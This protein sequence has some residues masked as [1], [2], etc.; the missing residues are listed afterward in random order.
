[1]K[2][3]KSGIVLGILSCVI[4]CS[5]PVYVQK[6]VSANLAKYRSY[7]WV[8]TQRDQNDKRSNA[9]AFAEAA[10]HNAA[11]AELDKRG[12]RE[13]N[14]NPDVLLSYDILVQRGTQA[15]SDPMYTRPF[16]R[17]YYNPWARRWGTIYYPSQFMGYDTY[18][19]PVREGTLTVTMMDANND[20]P[21]WQAWTT[22]Q[23]NS[24]KMTDAEASKA[25]RK[26]FRKL[27][28]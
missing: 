2:L 6:D 7:M 1:M 4:G 15:Q 24:R 3:I 14:S 13:V 10:I 17:V 18:E 8:E 27:G 9:S 5:S 12:W 19:S 20:K 25:V 16:T 21:V 22:E 23:L 11:N 28:K 26:I